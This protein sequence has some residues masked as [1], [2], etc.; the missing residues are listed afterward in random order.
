MTGQPERCR[1]REISLLLCARRVASVLRSARKTL[2]QIDAAYI[3][4]RCVM[5]TFY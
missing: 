4:L 1:P 3:A 2:V 5:V